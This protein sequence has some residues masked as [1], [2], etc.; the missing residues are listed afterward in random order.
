MIIL[1]YSYFLFYLIGLFMKHPFQ[2]PSISPIDD[3][4]WASH[5]F[6]WRQNQAK[7]N[8]LTLCCQRSCLINTHERSIHPT[9]GSISKKMICQVCAAPAPDY[10]NGDCFGYVHGADASTELTQSTRTHYEGK[11]MESWLAQLATGN[12]QPTGCSKWQL[13]LFVWLLINAFAQCLSN[14]A[15]GAMTTTTKA[16]AARTKSSIL[17]VETSHNNRNSSSCL[18]QGSFR[19]SRQTTMTTTTTT[20]TSTSTTIIAWQLGIGSIWCII[21]W[22]KFTFKC[23]IYTSASRS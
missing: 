14:Y 4:S 2:R 11:A 23:A 20:T 17:S 12:W 18:R 15:Y 8:T 16:T 6:N 1:L 22:I 5:V 9:S 7:I 19:M 13:Q 3:A 21:N 10:D